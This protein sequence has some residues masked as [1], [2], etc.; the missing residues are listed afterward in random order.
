MSLFQDG[1]FAEFPT[2][3]LGQVVKIIVSPNTYDAK[4][5]NRLPREASV[6]NL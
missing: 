1:T 2:I 5:Q 6:S 3:V 4:F